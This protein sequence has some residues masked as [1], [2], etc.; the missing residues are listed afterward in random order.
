MV[1]P[2]PD[3]LAEVVQPLVGT[4]RGESSLAQ[5]AGDTDCLCV[6]L[7]SLDLSE[8]HAEFDVVRTMACDFG[9]KAPIVEVE[10]GFLKGGV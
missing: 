4:R 2:R 1:A 3:T 10:D 5:L 7:Q 9:V 6:E 8:D